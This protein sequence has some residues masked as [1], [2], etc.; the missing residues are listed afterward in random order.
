[1]LH[2]K[3]GARSATSFAR[4]RRLHNADEFAFG[5]AKIDPF[6][7]E[8]HTAPRSVR[9]TDIVGVQYGLARL[10]FNSSYNRKTS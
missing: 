3:G 2:R 7:H 1:M 8:L 9:F 10:C 4:S 5:D 6:Q